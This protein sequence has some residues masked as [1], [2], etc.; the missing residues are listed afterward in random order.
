MWG[1]L[2]LAAEVETA[3]GW[4][5]RCASVI[6][7]VTAGRDARTVRDIKGGEERNVEGLHVFVDG[8]RVRGLAIPWSCVRPHHE[9]SAAL[10]TLRASRATPKAMASQ[11][12]VAL[13]VGAS[14]GIGRQ[15]AV[16]LAKNGYA[17]ERAA[18][19]ASPPSL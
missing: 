7:A 1:W 10:S 13:V 2:S 4:L 14:R 19:H 15:V 5:L 3:G 17:G 11:K 9:E 18:R 12:K 8:L 16:D 6:R